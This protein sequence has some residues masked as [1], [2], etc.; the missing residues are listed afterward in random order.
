MRM[1]KISKLPDEVREWIDIVEQD[2]F[3]CCEEQHLLVE[4]V[5]HCFRTEKIH[6]DVDQLRKYMSMCEKYLPFPLFPWQ[7]F[8][9]AL[10]DCCYWDDTGQPRWP[11]LFCE[12]GRGAG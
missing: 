9:I 8:V 7:K 5:Q 1:T 4:H 12:L 11:D 3:K 10:H 6:V 2:K